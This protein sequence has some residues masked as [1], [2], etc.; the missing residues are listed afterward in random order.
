[1]PKQQVL[2]PKRLVPVL[3][4]TLLSLQQEQR[5]QQEPVQQGLVQQQEPVQS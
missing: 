3:L 2:V 1:M 4:S 5:Q